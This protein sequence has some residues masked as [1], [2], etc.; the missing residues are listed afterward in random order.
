[1][2]IPIC[3]WQRVPIKEKGVI[4]GCDQQQEWLLE[5]WWERYSAKNGFPVTFADFGMSTQAHQ[6]C[7]E[8]GEIISV[9]IDPA[10]VKTCTKYTL[11]IWG[12]KLKKMYGHKLWTS[13]Y[14]WFK[15]ALC[16]STF[17]PYYCSVWIDLDCE[18][19][20]PIDEVF[21]MCDAASQLAVVREYGTKHL[22]KLDPGV[23]YNGGVIGFIH[24]TEIIKKWAE[25]SIERNDCF[26][27]DDLLLSS[28]IYE[29][30]WPVVELPEVYNWKYICGMNLDAIIF[31]WFLLM[32]RIL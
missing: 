14:Q 16:L 17:L 27:A 7:K 6:W 25:A 1:M 26:L 24:G 18:I 9:S 21:S 13:R 3:E 28:L 4:V 11:G 20:G 29:L 19:L 5:W 2:N 23:I 15:K 32:V 31:H 22:L 8:R 12:K 30:Q 10:F